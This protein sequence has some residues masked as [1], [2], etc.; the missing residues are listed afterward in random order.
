MTITVTVNG[1]AITHPVSPH[2]TLLEFLRDDLHLT[3]TKECCAEGEC[4][5][6]TILLNGEAVNSCLVLAAEAEGAVLP[7]SKGWKPGAASIRF[8]RRSSTKVRFSAVFV[9][10]A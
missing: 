3:G 6:C 2:H 10:P 9:F 5:A 7:R 4:G 1:A 8:S